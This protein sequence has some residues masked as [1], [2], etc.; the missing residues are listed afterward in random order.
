MFINYARPLNHMPETIQFYP[1]DAAYRLQDGKAVKGTWEK[2]NRL[3]R[4]LFYDANGKDVYL[5][6]DGVLLIDKWIDQPSTT[7]KTTRNLAG[8]RRLF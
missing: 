4:T 6:V 2:K 8:D 5:Y 3:A 7:Y 1:F